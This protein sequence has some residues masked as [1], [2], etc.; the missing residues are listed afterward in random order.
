MTFAL[1]MPPTPPRVADWEFLQSGNI[2]P[3]ETSSLLLLA[4]RELKG[5]NRSLHDQ[6]LFR[7]ITRVRR[8]LKKISKHT[9]L[10][11]IQ[12]AMFADDTFGNEKTGEIY[13][14]N[15]PPK[16][17]GPLKRFSP[18]R[19]VQVGQKWIDVY[20]KNLLGE[21][22]NIVCKKR[23]PLL[24]KATS[25]GLATYIVNA[26]GISHAAAVTVAGVTLLVLAVA[27]KKTI[28]NKSDKELLD[29]IQERKPRRKPIPSSR[30]PSKRK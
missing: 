10:D 29:T 18:S 14:L 17:R 22:R 24:S 11:I 8:N 9:C 15:P 1:F 28:C 26:C 16:M 23:N 25:L 4:Q 27:A 6:V 12:T 20:F 3:K 30:K 5:E 7:E 21:V 13:F 19:V 2:D